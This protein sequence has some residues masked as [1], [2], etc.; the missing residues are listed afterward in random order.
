MFAQSAELKNSLG[1]HFAAKQ[2]YPAGVEIL[3][4]G[5]AAH[6]LY[7]VDFGLIKLVHF[8]S[9]GD[10]LLT[11]LCGPGD[12]VGGGSSILRTLSPVAAV[13]ATACELFPIPTELFCRLLQS[14]TDLSW[15]FHR[16]Q[17]MTANRYMLRLAHFG[18]YSARNHFEH[19]LWS[20]CT[21]PD[22]FTPD[23]KLHL[24]LK[25]WEIAQF[26]G[27]TP[28][29]LSRLLKALERDGLIQRD[30]GWIKVSN[31]DK[32]WHWKDDFQYEARPGRE[33]FPGNSLYSRGPGHA[34]QQLPPRTVRAIEPY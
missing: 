21:M 31:A 12:L 34:V 15:T 20:I 6:T 32:L 10:T 1:L 30:N 27:I 25:L 4:Q 8:G 11:D 28:S 13:T 22:L 2:K 5:Q 29:Y 26:L 16:Y 19:F 23:K 7:L 33:A 14:D 17:A 18:C 3:L 9:N 24:P